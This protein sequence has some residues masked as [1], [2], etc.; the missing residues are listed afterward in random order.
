MTE[1]QWTMGRRGRT[2]IAGLLLGAC[3]SVRVDSTHELRPVLLEGPVQVEREWLSPWIEARAPF[4]E[5]LP[6][7]NVD[8]PE[9]ASFRVDLRVEGEGVM[10]HWLDL[11]GW[12]SWPSGDRSPVTCEAGAVAV[13]V[14]KLERPATRARLRV[15]A[16]GLGPGEAVR[17]RA[18]A[19]CFTR[20]PAGRPTSFGPPPRTASRVEVPFRS[21][22]SE[23]PELAARVC[24]PTSV[25]MVLEH[26]GHSW[27]TEQVAATLYDP[28]HDIYGNWNRAVQGAYLLGVPG[29][30]L[31]VGSWPE[32]EAL[33]RGGR[34][35]VISIGVEASQLTGA[36]YASTDGHLLVLCGFDGRGNAWVQDPAAP[37]E[38]P[39][40]RLYSLAE[41]EVVWLR[42]GGFAYLIAPGLELDLGR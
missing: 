27:T 37:P 23:A 24:S 6:S 11:G 35:L 15:R 30:L 2:V 16:R 5:L 25:A 10:T 32:A 31:R 8:V 21:Q 20:D 33:M 12:G 13:D 22:K 17:L 1:L 9:G 41:L 3:A 40:P 18:L 19:C 7:W 36:P 34:P 4:H 39:G 14:L 42:R 26:H 28:E 38:E 29:R